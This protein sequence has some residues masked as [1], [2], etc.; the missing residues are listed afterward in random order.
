MISKLQELCVT[1]KF[2]L[3]SLKRACNTLPSKCWADLSLEEEPDMSLASTYYD[4]I[5]SL[6]HIVQFFEV[7]EI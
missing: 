3:H 5:K 1:R 2:S 4:G 6:Q 7:S